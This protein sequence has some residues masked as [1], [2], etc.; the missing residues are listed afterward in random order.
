MIKT[1]KET[2]TSLQDSNY[3]KTILT[4]SVP[5]TVW[6]WSKYF[7]LVSGIF[8]LFTVAAMAYFLPQVSRYVNDNVPDGFI[9]VKNGEF[10]SSLPQPYVL[11][12]PDSIIMVDEKGEKASLDSYSQG[13]LVTKK[14]MIIKDD[15]GDF[16]TLVISEM[17]DDFYLNKQMVFDFFSKNAE[18]IF[19]VLVVVSL[20]AGLFLGAVVWAFH[21]LMFMFYAFILW[22][23]ALL[24]KHR[25]EYATIFKFVVYASVVPFLFAAILVLAPNPIM[26]W[27][28]FGLFLFFTISWMKSV[29]AKK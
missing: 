18:V 3:A 22:L 15:T 11:R 8:Y 26:S 23:A 1:F 13:V 5:D 29:S 7:L 9:E 17:V 27:L 14:E 2:I 19:A 28:N 4:K 12:S 21:M 24:V 25:L 20:V 16:Q 6:Y 10:N